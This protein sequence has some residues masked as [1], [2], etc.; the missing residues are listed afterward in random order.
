MAKVKAKSAAV[1]AA[2]M[3]KPAEVKP[4][5][6][7]PVEVVAKPAMTDI[8]RKVAESRKAL[9]QPLAEGQAFFESPEGYIMIGEK[10]KDHVWCRDMN[11]GKGGW[12]NPRR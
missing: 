10:E 6:V 4:A 1:S 12:I 8:Q 7:A 3:E 11:N 2:V 5:A 9:A